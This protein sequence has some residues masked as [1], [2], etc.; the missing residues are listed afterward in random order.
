M[1]QM[2]LRDPSN[3][4]GGD[5]RMRRSSRCGNRRAAITESMAAKTLSAR[6]L[7]K[8]RPRM[9]TTA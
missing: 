9:L 6:A 2:S 4:K 5:W 7:R 8:L 3:L 1:I